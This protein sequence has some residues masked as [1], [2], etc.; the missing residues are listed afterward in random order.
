M[1]TLEEVEHWQQHR[2]SIQ[3][4]HLSPPQEVAALVQ[5]LYNVEMASRN[6]IVHMETLEQQL[7]SS[8]DRVAKLKQ[9]LEDMQIDIVV[10]ISGFDIDWLDDEFRQNWFGKAIVIHRSLLPSYGDC[11][12]PQ[13]EDFF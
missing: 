12:G 6:A 1:P 11:I 4:P 10:C 9:T 3:G 2:L 13:V 8:N 5:H 7:L